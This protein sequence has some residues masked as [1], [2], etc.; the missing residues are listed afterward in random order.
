MGI[1]VDELVQQAKQL[2]PD[3]QAILSD[4][5]LELVSPH[6]PEWQLAWGAECEA[7][8]AACERGEMLSYDSDEVMEGLRKKYRLS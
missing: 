3:E 7:R 5:I 6:D 2:S 8:I 1:T 4:R